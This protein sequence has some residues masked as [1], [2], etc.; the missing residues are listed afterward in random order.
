MG[1]GNLST[2]FNYIETLVSCVNKLFS[3]PHHDRQRHHQ[4]LCIRS[5]LGRHQ[6]ATN[7]R[8]SRCFSHVSRCL[9][10]VLC[11]HCSTG[12]VRW[13]VHGSSTLRVLCTPTLQPTIDEVH[14]LKRPSLPITQSP[15][16]P[17]HTVRFQ[18]PDGCSFLLDI[19]LTHA[20]PMRVMAAA[21]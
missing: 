11:S 10:W 16:T 12:W 2:T 13:N 15:V 4:W 6:I 1:N 18:R 21:S 7:S 20:H 5:N 8:R 19:T 17:L 14:T 3:L 9:R